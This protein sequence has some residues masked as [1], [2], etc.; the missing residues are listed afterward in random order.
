M[1]TLLNQQKEPLARRQTA[2]DI[3]SIIFKRFHIFIG[4]PL[5]IVAA[6]VAGTLAMPRLYEATTEISVEDVNF[7][8]IG[9]SGVQPQESKYFSPKEQLINSEINVVRGTVVLEPVARKLELWKS[10]NLAGNNEEERVA[11]AVSRLADVVKVEPKLDSWIIRIIVRDGDPRLAATIANE[12]AS[13][14]INTSIELRRLPQASGFYL[15]KLNKEKEELAQLQNEF[16]KLRER[17]RVVNYDAEMDLK[18]ESRAS[19]ER[20]LTEVRTEILSKQAKIQKIREFIAQNTDVLVPIPEIAAV[21]IVEDLNYRLVNLRIEL[22][23]LL[24]RYTEEERQVQLLKGQ[25]AET[26][27]QLRAEVR[28][29]VD[30]ETVDL[31]KLEAER[32]ALSASVA[33]IDAEI[34]SKTGVES[35]YRNMQQRI[36]DKQEIVSD[37]NKKYTDSLYA[38]E[39]DARLG[40]VRQISPAL[41]PGDPVSP[42]LRMALL[43]GIPLALLIGLATVMALDYFDRSF[44]TPERVEEIL[45]LP[46]L[47]SITQHNF[48]REPLFRT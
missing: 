24:R 23:S 45:G 10:W 25:I 1:D 15:D 21:R 42:N 2:R 38:G 7:D 18:L 11:A 5:V 35:E 29:I 3:L 46:V 34:L 8:N 9:I 17:S 32:D 14:Y 41:T 13:Q 16:M 28:K 6:I 12:I 36:T 48:A 4:L 27:N 37:L 47:A 44:S 40:R 22:E 39:S 26:E 43:F 19:F 30:R 31:N 33:Q 20:R